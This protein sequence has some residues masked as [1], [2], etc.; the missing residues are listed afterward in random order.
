[1]NWNID[2][3]KNKIMIDYS[4]YLKNINKQIIRRIII[5]SIKRICNIFQVSINQI[6]FDNNFIIVIINEDNVPALFEFLYSIKTALELYIIERENNMKDLYQFKSMSDLENVINKMRLNYGDEENS[7]LTDTFI[8]EGN[9]GLTY[10]WLKNVAKYVGPTNV[11][12]V[13][14]DY[15]NIMEG[16]LDFIDELYIDI[17]NIDW[18]SPK[19]YIDITAS[20]ISF[21]KNGLMR[22]WWD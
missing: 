18:L 21:D 1:M 14:S 5:K 4:L 6:I 15:N 7:S 11:Y 17:K 3:N 2:R 12:I 13:E 8:I 9:S 10:G 16:D 19:N 22:L 20:E